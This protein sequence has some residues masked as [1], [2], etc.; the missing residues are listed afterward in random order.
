VNQLG[1]VQRLTAAEPSEP[2]TGNAAEFAVDDLD[3]DI[4]RRLVAIAPSAE[5]RRDVLMVFD[6][7]IIE[8]QSR[9]H[10]IDV[11]EEG[12]R[13]FSRI[14]TPPLTLRDLKR[15]AFVCDQVDVHASAMFRAHDR[16]IEIHSIRRRH[17]LAVRNCQDRR[18]RA[19]PTDVEIVVEL[20][21]PERVSIIAWTPQLLDIR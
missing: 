11:C 2:R 18:T 5:E 13:G 16:R 8:N 21:E 4:E 1:G 7:Q 14:E 19:V 12:L 17:V 15:L 9:K 6:R 20:I 10:Q 3:Q